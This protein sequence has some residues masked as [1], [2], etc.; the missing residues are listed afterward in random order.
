MM[1][2]PP[3]SASFDTVTLARHADPRITMEVY[4]HL[5]PGYLQ[6]QVDRLQFGL[7]IPDA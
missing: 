4:G 3:C 5:T 1:A 2:E 6:A 7:P